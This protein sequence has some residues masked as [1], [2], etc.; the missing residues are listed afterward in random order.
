MYAMFNE[1][2]ML[3][4]RQKSHDFGVSVYFFERGGEGRGQGRAFCLLKSRFS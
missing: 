3:I 1:A 4:G 2:L